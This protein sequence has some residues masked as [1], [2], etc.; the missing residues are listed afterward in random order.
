[1]CVIDP[2]NEYLYIVKMGIFMFL[3]DWDN[4]VLTNDGPIRGKYKSRSNVD[5]CSKWVNGEGKMIN[6]PQLRKED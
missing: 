5:F 3:C 2:T 1:M 4:Y 6:L